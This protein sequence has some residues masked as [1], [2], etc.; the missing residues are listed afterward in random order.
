MK[1]DYPLIAPNPPRLSTLGTAL[2]AIEDSGVYSNGGPVVRGFEAAATD[3]LFGGRGACLAV[4]NATLGL[5]LAI[6]ALL[7]NRPAEGRLALVPAF[8]FAATGHAVIAAGLTPLLYDADPDS[9]LPDAAAEEALLRRYGD[10]IAAIVPYATFGKTLDLDR[11]ARLAERHQVGVAIDAAASLGTTDA[12]DGL[13]F[14]AGAPF[15]VVYSMHATKSFATAEGGLIHS[16]DVHLIDTLRT[17]SNFG[18]DANRC[19]VMPG[20]NAK[21]PEV[22]GLLAREKLAELDTVS[23]RRAALAAAYRRHLAAL[24]RQPADDGRQ[25]AQFFSVLLPRDI[26]AR[27]DAIIADLAE[28]GIGSAHYFAPHLGQQPYFRASALT[29]PTPVADDLAA[30]M[31]SLPITDRMTEADVEII[32]N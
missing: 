22:G 11:Y 21:L 8:T 32:C 9:W 4:A 13:N 2:K 23:D 5:T 31:L 6:R 29:E 24:D 14:G 26:A 16:G 18:L 12:R 7:G 1:T 28:A 27:R 25:A 10:R 3:R 17:M 30:R 15:A 20:F 19:A